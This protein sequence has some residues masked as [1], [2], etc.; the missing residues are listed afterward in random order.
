MIWILCF[1]EGFQLPMP[2]SEAKDL[3]Y[4][5]GYREKI[6][7]N[8]MARYLTEA[9]IWE[10]VI[11]NPR[12]DD[13]KEEVLRWHI[14]YG[15][16][17]NI[18]DCAGIIVMVVKDR[19]RDKWVWESAVEYACKVMGLSEICLELLPILRGQLFFQGEENLKDSDVEGLEDLIW[20]YGEQYPDENM[21][22]ESIWVE[23]VIELS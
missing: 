4:L 21:Y 11:L 15:I 22:P 18:D 16:N 13:L 1:A 10:Q 23:R 20:D 3:L 8:L 7:E 5:H 12:Q 14:N 2:K 9:E 17:Q 6:W 19:F